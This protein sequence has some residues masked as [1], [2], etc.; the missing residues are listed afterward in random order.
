MSCLAI[1]MI[2]TKNQ[3]IWKEL[4]KGDAL[5]YPEF[6]QFVRLMITITSPSTSDVERAYSTLEIITTKHR[7]QLKI[8]YLETLFVLANVQILVKSPLQYENKVAYL[9]ENN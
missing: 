8:D 5:E 6:C 4:L 2:N 3:E 1:L 7:N 9:E